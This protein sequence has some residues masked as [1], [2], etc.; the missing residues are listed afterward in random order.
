MEDL[1][2]KQDVPCITKQEMKKTHENQHK[3]AGTMF[4]NGKKVKPKIK[5]K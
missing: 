2:T 4:R 3:M 1:V 5:E